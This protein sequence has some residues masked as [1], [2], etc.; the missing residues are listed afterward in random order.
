MESSKSKISNLAGSTKLIFGSSS[1]QRLAYAERVCEGSA[2]LSFPAE[3]SAEWDLA[4]APFKKW[5]PRR[6][7]AHPSVFLY[8][9]SIN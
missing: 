2:R 6:H 3:Y 1:F 4:P 5:L 8:K 9:H 7:R